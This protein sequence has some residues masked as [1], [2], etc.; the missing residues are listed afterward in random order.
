M[1]LFNWMTKTMAKGPAIVNTANTLARHYLALEAEYDSD[2]SQLYSKIIEQRYSTLPLEDEVLQS[3]KES[4]SEK[5]SLDD[6]VYL[7]LIHETELAG[8]ELDFQEE[9]KK[10]IMKELDKYEGI[11]REDISLPPDIVDSLRDN[12]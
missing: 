11:P 7:V 3:L 12:I 5:T 2:R 8:V 6:F 9:V 10:V 4:V 1:G